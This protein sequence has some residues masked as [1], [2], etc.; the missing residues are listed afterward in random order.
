LRVAEKIKKLLIQMDYLEKIDNPPL[1]NI[2]LT[3]IDL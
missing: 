3:D 1:I 2:F